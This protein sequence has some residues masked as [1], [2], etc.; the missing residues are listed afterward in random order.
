MTYNQWGIEL[1]S[2]KYSQSSFDLRNEILAALE[3]NVMSLYYTIPLYCDAS[4]SLDSKRLDYITDE[5]N[6]M[7]SFGGLRFLDYRYSDQEWAKYVAGQGGTL[8]YE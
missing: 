5:Y 1:N 8:N 7:Y 6:I 3:H 4:V 2:G